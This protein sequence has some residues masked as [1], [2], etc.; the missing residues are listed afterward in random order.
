MSDPTVL[1]DLIGP[2]L[3]DLARRSNTDLR[4]WLDQVHTLRGCA[5]PVRL[6]G[7]T[8]TLDAATGQILSQYSTVNEPHG[9]LMV[10]CKNRRSSRCPSCA[11]EY[12]ADTY[13]LMKA[14]LAGG[15][16]GVPA[17]VGLHPRVFA[18]LTAPSFGAVH[19]GPAKNGRMRVCHPR[20]EGTTCWTRHAAD[21][22]QIG[23]PID[24]A[25]YDYDSHVIWNAHAG[26]L[27]RRF[28][29]YLR[30][31]LAAAAGLSQKAFNAR[32]RV[33]FAKVAEYQ[34]RGLVHYHSVIRLD[35][36]TDQPGDWPPPPVWATPSTL[37]DAVR[38]AANAVQL[39]V[40]VPSLRRTFDLTFGSQVDVQPIS[41]FAADED[42]TDEAVAGYI[43]KYATKAA[44]TAGTLDRRITDY[45][46]RH[47]P[48]HGVTPHAAR[49]IRTCWRLGDLIEHPDLADA[50][51]R[52]WAHMLGFR[53]HFTTKSRAYSTTYGTLRN[54]RADYVR[55]ATNRP[56]PDD[57]TTLVLAHWAYAGQG[58][59]PGEAALAATTS[60]HRPSEVKDGTR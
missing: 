22:P 57:D 3:K 43:A 27:W 58:F 35:G 36:R 52:K 55:Q 5:E 47:L 19:V 24:P 50:K 51:L 1:A 28:T 49:L 48:D 18:T 11:E 46:L 44:E 20:R 29:T 53:G 40:A 9:Q 37:Q 6:T 23:Q 16:K 26:D 21:D 54:A 10:R 14:G 30:R 60:G 39:D 42:V 45:D 7:E 31:H 34:A 25:T 17:S 38:S 59:T 13:H 33:S 8:M 32:V 2:V 12:R 15:S 4:R 56:D 41:A